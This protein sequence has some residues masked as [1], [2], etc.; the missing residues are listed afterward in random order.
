M[1]AGQPYASL[2]DA[3]QRSGMSRPTA[4]RII[5]SGGFDGMYSL[6]IPPAMRQRGRMTRRDLLL[7]VADLDRY[8]RGVVPWVARGSARGSARACPAVARPVRHAVRRPG[9]HPPVRAAG[10]DLG[11]AGRRRA[12]GARHGRQPARRRLLCGHAR[13]PGRRRDGHRPVARPAGAAIGQRGV[14]RRGEGG[15]P[16]PARAQRP[17]R[18]LPHPRRR[19]PARS[20]PPSSTMRRAPSP[21]RCSRPGCCWCA[22][23]SDAPGRGVSRCGP[24]AAGSSARCGR[25]GW[26]AASTAVA[27]LVA[28]RRP[29]ATCRQR[30]GPAGGGCW[31]MPAGSG[32]RR[33][34]TSSRPGMD[35]SRAARPSSGTPARAAAGW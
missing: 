4:E 20:T 26:R 19:R 31:C 12:R 15:H 17:S 5:V 35:G 9:G 2:S 32:S 30:A 7:Q 21:A 16:D 22:A 6:D 3:W 10:D 11:R 28:V 18:H 8:T 14:R 13:R 25:P 29:T 24:P 1:I 27:E 34:P 33:T 23:R